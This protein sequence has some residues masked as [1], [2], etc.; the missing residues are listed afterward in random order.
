[1]CHQSDDG[2]ETLRSP[3]PPLKRGAKSGR[4]YQAFR[5]TVLRQRLTHPTAPLPPAPCPLPPAPL[6]PCPLLPAPLP[7]APCPPAPIYL[8]VVRILFALNLLLP[9]PEA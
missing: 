6:L 9:F 1:M 5:K 4:M 3:Q 2:A 7:P 8:C